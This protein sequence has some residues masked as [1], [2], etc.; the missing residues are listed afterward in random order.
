MINCGAPPSWYEE[1]RS[2]PLF[3]TLPVKFI[4]TRSSF[5]TT[6]PSP[7]ET[8]CTTNL[9]LGSALGTSIVAFLPNAPFTSGIGDAESTGFGAAAAAD[10]EDDADESA[11]SLSPLSSSLPQ[12]DAVSA[13]AGTIRRAASRRRTSILRSLEWGPATLGP[14]TTGPGQAEPTVPTETYGGRNGERDRGPAHPR[15][16]GP[17]PC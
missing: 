10:G 12:P 15:C 7:S 4:D 16:A 9:S 6:E 13:R 17:L 3:Q 1:P 8:V 11:L 2:L 14:H 5:F